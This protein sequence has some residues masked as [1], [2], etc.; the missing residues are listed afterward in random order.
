MSYDCA[1]SDV[2]SFLQDFLKKLERVKQLK[3]GS[4]MAACPAHSDKKPSLHITPSQDQILLK[5]FSGCTTESIVSAMGLE[6]KDLF[7]DNWNSRTGGGSGRIRRPRHM[8]TN[9]QPG[10][11]ADVLPAVKPPLPA[12]S[13]TPATPPPDFK[14]SHVALMDSP[15]VMKMFQERYGLTADTVENMPW[16]LHD[17]IVL[18][19]S[20]FRTDCGAIR[21]K[22][23]SRPSP[24]YCR[25]KAFWQYPAYKDT[26]EFTVYQGTNTA[27]AFLTAGEEKAGLLWQVTQCTV[28]LI[29]GGE[30]TSL[31][32]K[33]V[34][35]I[36]S[37]GVKRV[38]VV[39]DADD[40]G[41][42]GSV[43][44][45]AALEAAGVMAAAPSW[46]TAVDA[47]SLA[48]VKGYDINDLMK[49]QGAEA[50]LS[51]LQSAVF[52]H[53]WQKNRWAGNVMT[54]ND[55]G[56]SAARPLVKG[57]INRSTINMVY[58]DAGSLKSMIVMDMAAHIAKGKTWLDGGDVLP[59]FR[60]KQ[61]NVGWV[62][63]DN[64]TFT[65]KGRLRAFH[66]V[67]NFKE[68]EFVILNFPAGMDLSGHPEQAESLRQMADFYSL[69]L[70][71]IDVFQNCYTGDE[72]R[73]E[74][75]QVLKNLRDSFSGTDVSIIL[76]HHTSK[77]GEMRGSTSISGQAD[78]AIE[79]KRAKNPRNFISMTLPKIRDGQ[80]NGDS[81]S[82]SFHCAHRN[83]IDEDGDELEILDRAWFKREEN[84][85]AE[86]SDG[87]GITSD[88]RVIDYLIAHPSGGNRKTIAGGIGISEFTVGKALARLTHNGTL[89][90]KQ[91]G[92]RQ[93]KIW[94][95]KQKGE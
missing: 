80:D 26:S 52:L 47:A 81:I 4:Y 91:A 45:C 62:N 68:S 67:H 36:K 7:S 50:V 66:E 92:E 64:P 37:S 69:G 23:A 38:C 15:E 39:F 21:S 11:G 82:A 73:T 94:T 42:K 78:A 24:E 85:V 54:V 2:N 33:M 95:I 43:K 14:K 63:N 77:N 89:E 9:T 88:Q 1:Q 10:R 70:I 74:A 25:M 18:Y 55:C 93:G 19:Y 27:Q 72:W 86:E 31:N 51:F 12:E 41:S 61:A 58:G 75:G 13:A 29:R 34:E 17:N 48:E 49:D 30:S 65:I 53:T 28:F 59:G 8:M 35:Q 60:T 22:H 16:G 3:D 87:P 90:C 84:D 76:I 32:D 5:C 56:G 6:M 83:E 79:I 71:V 46:E 20:D 40:A 57:L 44:A